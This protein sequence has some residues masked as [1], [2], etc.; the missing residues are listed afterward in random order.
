M[1]AVGGFVGGW[2]FSNQFTIRL[3]CAV[4]PR[5]AFDELI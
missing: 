3:L 1:L 4:L 5:L 2:M